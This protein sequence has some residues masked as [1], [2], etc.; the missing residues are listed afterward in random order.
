MRRRIKAEYKGLVGCA[1]PQIRELYPKN[2]LLYSIGKGF[3]ENRE[4]EVT[5][6]IYTSLYL[7]KHKPAYTYIHLSDNPI[8]LI[9]TNKYKL[10]SNDYY[11][12]K[13]GIYSPIERFKC[14][15]GYNYF[16]K[17]GFYMINVLNYLYLYFSICY[18]VMGGTDGFKTHT[19]KY[20]IENTNI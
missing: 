4:G 10:L 15:V 17:V 2:T 11:K 6:L 20:I 7:S 5:H 1:I 13:V 14:K 9:Y 8:K 18:Y 12:S 16:S 3:K 19:L